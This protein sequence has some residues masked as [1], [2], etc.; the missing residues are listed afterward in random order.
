TNRQRRNGVDEPRG[1]FPCHPWQ[2]AGARCPPNTGRCFFMCYCQSWTAS[3]EHRVL[4]LVSW[5][6]N[7]VRKRIAQLDRLAEETAADVI[8]HQETKVNDALFPAEPLEALGYVHQAVAGF[9]GYNG[10]AICS[11]LPLENIERHVH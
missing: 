7:S 3:G 6:I 4:T 9:G 10:V 8:C 1:G 11:K 5:N 2:R